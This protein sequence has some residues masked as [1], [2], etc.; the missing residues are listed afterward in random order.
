MPEP[1]SQSQTRKSRNGNARSPATRLCD[2][3]PMHALATIAARIARSRHTLVLTGAGMSAESGVPTFRDAQTGLWA[4]YRPEELAT[5][6]AFRRDPAL[7]WRWYAWRRQLVAAAQPNA[8][9]R[10]LAALAQRVSLAL[11]TQNVDGMHQRAGST[12]VICLHGDLF[13]NLCSVTKLPIDQA[14]MDTHDGEE[15]PPSPHHADGLARPGVVWFGENLPH[16]AYEAALESARR[17][18]VVLSIGTSGLVHPAAGL[19]GEAL[20][21]GAWFAEIN[22]ERTVLS[23]SADLVVADTAAHAL[24]AILAA[25]PTH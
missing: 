12:G 2:T 16:D 14:W 18:D 22:P 20:R 8:G 15:P 23:E 9:H 11:V 21:H 1:F 5:P 7:I 19:P 24:P 4:R 25:L 17:C 6:E 10:A 3:E 13:R